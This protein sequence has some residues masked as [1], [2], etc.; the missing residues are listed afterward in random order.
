MVESLLTTLPPRES[1]GLGW[2]TWDVSSGSD[3][4]G[5]RLLSAPSK[6]TVH[7]SQQTRGFR[8]RP[9]VLSSKLKER[10]LGYVA[11]P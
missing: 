11:S 6:A 9:A 7:Y 1:A 4:V 2:D 5:F 8:L 10:V 3:G